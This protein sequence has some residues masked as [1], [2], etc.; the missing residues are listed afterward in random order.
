MS[1]FYRNAGPSTKTFYGVT[2]NPG[3]TKEVSGRIYHH[4]FILVSQPKEPPVA[5]APK[6][7]NSSVADEAPK[8]RGRSRLK[9]EPTIV[10]PEDIP[11]VEVESES[12]SSDVLVESSEAENNIIGQE[13][14]ING[15]DHN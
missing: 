5:A 11:S 7:K 9:P 12:P 1:L 10:E 4:K 3:D 13:E 2:F 6:Y 8:G 14:A 15:P